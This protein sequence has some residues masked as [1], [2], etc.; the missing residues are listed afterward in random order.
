M[1]SMFVMTHEELKDW[2]YLHNYMLFS[3]YY[4]LYSG[5]E[6]P[7]ASLAVRPQAAFTTQ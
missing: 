5:L 4:A 6:V 3:L 2:Y 7:R 1:L